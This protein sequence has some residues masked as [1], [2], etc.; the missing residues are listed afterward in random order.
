MKMI[1]YT[2]KTQPTVTS[3]GKHR[4]WVDFYLSGLAMPYDYSGELSLM[5]YADNTSELIQL[6][7]SLDASELGLKPDV[8]Y[9]VRIFEVKEQTLLFRTKFNKEEVPK[10][11]LPLVR[12]VYPN[13]VAKELVDVQPMNTNRVEKVNDLKRENKM[14]MTSQE[15][16]DEINQSLNMIPQLEP[17][18]LEQKNAHTGET[19]AETREDYFKTMFF[20]LNAPHQGFYYLLSKPLLAEMYHFKRTHNLLWEPCQPL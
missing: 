13:L 19:L 6:I 2:F 4:Y 10:W 15:V 12:Q 16:F 7:E 14:K 1:E 20:W 3:T 5:L 8:K 11:D 18:M 9:N 17:Y